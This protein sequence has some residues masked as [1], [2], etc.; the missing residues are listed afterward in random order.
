MQDAERISSCD[1]Q[2]ALASINVKV[3]E[4]TIRKKLHT[5]D[6]YRRKARRK[7]LLFRK[8]NRARLKFTHEHL[9]KAQ[10][11]WNNVLWMDKAKIE[12]VDDSSRRHTV[13]GKHQ[14]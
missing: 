14:R 12:L 8:N 11:F 10:D 1:L 4:S 5:L 2:V 6:L 3:H 7:S 13:Y 9:G